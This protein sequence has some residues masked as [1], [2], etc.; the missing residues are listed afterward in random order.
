MPTLYCHNEETIADILD[1]IRSTADESVTISIDPES[2]Y[3]QNLENEAVLR[4][5]AHRL[6]KKISIVNESAA[7][8]NVVDEAAPAVMMPVE[9]ATTQSNEEEAKKSD[10]TADNSLAESKVK[11]KKSKSKSKFRK[12]FTFPFVLIPLRSEE[13]V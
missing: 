7:V 11:P 5:A 1:K 10:E 9:A 6:G 12:M 3:W 13:V 8:S 2:V 4:E